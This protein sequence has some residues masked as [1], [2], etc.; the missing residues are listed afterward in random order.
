MTVMKLGDDTK[1]HRIE[2]STIRVLDTVRFGS[3]KEAVA[4]GVVGSIVVPE[5]V[6]NSS[7]DV[8]LD[9]HHERD[10]F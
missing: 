6:R 3:Y 5:E 1:P 10:E 4:G 2:P 7:D 9:I 8:H